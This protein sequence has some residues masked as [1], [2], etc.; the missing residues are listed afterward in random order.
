MRDRLVG[1]DRYHILRIDATGRQVTA[2]VCYWAYTSA[3]D[4]GGGNYGWKSTL[5]ATDPGAGIAVQWVAMTAP[6]DAPT[7][8]LPPQTGTAE[9]PV[10]DVFGAWRITGHNMA[11]DAVPQQNS[12]PAPWP[13][14]VADA[15]SCVDQ[16]PDPLERRLF[17]RNG[18]HPRSDFPT[19]PPY[20]GWPAAGAE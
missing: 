13:S 17:L 18:V 5:P 20:P 19:L 14:E 8:P 16:A 11:A 12:D 1:T 9:S 15:R 3:L 2:G 4:L 7:P 10:D 6:E